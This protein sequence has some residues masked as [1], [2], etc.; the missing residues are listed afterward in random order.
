[1][2]AMIGELVLEQLDFGVQVENRLVLAGRLASVKT[3]KVMRKNI[4]I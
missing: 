2:I 1:M 3:F 4:R